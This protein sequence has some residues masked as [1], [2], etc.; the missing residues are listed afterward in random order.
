MPYDSREKAL[1]AGLKGNASRTT[2]RATEIA[3]AAATARWQGHEPKRPSYP[4][5]SG[6]ELDYWVERIPVAVR[7]SMSRPQLRRRATLLARQAA[8]EA[9]LENAKPPTDTPFAL[10]HAALRARGQR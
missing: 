2:E 9:A 7:L 3:R 10:L 4:L 5:L 1:A 6:A 8:A